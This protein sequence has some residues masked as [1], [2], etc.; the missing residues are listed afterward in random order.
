[1]MAIH[2]NEYINVFIEEAVEYIEQLDI[3][4]VSLEKKQT[5][6]ETIKKIYRIMHTMKGISGIIGFNELSTLMHTVESLFSNLAEKKLKVTNKIVESLYHVIDILKAIIRDLQ[7]GREV[8]VDFEKECRKFESFI[9]KEIRE[10]EG[11]GREEGFVYTFTP[12]DF[13]EK[14]TKAREKGEKLYR[15]DF[16]I[17]GKEELKN[18]RRRIL[19]KR[20]AEFGEIL[21]FFPKRERDYYTENE[22]HIKLLFLGTMNK[23]NSDDLKKVDRIHHLAYEEIDT[24]NLQ[25]AAG[26]ATQE[27]RDGKK[28]RETEITSISDENTIKVKVDKLDRLLNYAQ[29]LTIIN[30]SFQNFYDRL[31]NSELARDIITTLDNSVDSLTKTTQSL[32]QEI[33]RARM[34]P[35]GNLFRRFFRP[36][37]D[38]SRSC[39]KKVALKT[40]GE[41]EEIDKNTIDLLFEPLLH[42]VRNAIDHG[43]ENPEERNLLSKDEEAVL[44]LRSY[45]KQNRLF[46]EIADDGRGID[47][48]TI[49]SHAIEKGFIQ[50]DTVLN[51][52]ELLDLIFLPSFSTKKVADHLAGRG[53]GMNIVKEAVKKI[54][55]DIRIQTEREKGTTFII[56]L[57]TTMAIISALIIESS[58]ERYAIPLAPILEIVNVEPQKIK[59]VYG[60]K[61]FSMRDR[62]IP[63]IS[64]EEYFDLDAVLEKQDLLTIVIVESE[65]TVYGLIVEKVIGKQEIVTKSLTLSLLATKGISGVTILGDGS[66]VLIIDVDA[67]GE[68]F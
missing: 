8:S 6:T 37:R 36:A 60:K 29:E 64:C 30:L 42:L 45:S 48:E 57:P 24:R 68:Y 55:G 13:A 2:M 3:L 22:M 43:I 59:T 67:V 61:T 25:K 19:F 65:S 58:N 34:V 41:E 39:G 31:K 14:I 21:D 53:M 23:K 56:S 1:M 62:I 4:V 9:S 46:I 50:E 38:I 52:E 26:A 33:M 32:H 44:Q 18:A 15:I 27:E 17:D 51:N 10:K 16:S 49:R 40:S 66:I 47:I 35:V 54:S 7:K 20:L 63:L 28:T 11:K 5:D 12:E